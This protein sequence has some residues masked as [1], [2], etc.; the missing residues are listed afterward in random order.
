MSRDWNDL[1]KAQ[2]QAKRFLCI[3][4]DPD[5]T[6]IPAHLRGASPRETIVAFNSAIIDATGDIAG[7]YK[8]N[9]A[10]YEAYGEEGWAALRET[11]R[12]IHTAAPTVPVILDAKR[13]DIGN[14][15]EGYVRSIFDDLEADAVTLHPYLGAE[16]IAP[17]L[18]RS[19]KGVIVLCRTSNPGAGEFQDLIVDGEPLYKRVAKDVVASWN[20]KGNCALVVGA[21]YPEELA[22]VRDIAPHLPI[23]IPGIG[24]QG[25]DLTAAVK[26]GRDS[27]GQ[28]FIISASRSILYASNGED[29]A[30][31]ARSEAQEMDSAIRTAL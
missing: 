2:W 18:S 12:Y 8:P 15:N 10:F 4:L 27:N 17:F 30:E 14:T 5:M 29:F 21:T 23:L 9:T 22:Q 6:K 7:F 16:S 19:D 31:A 28:G 11:I 20:A 1:L 13:G 3:G 26:A 24:V 25:G